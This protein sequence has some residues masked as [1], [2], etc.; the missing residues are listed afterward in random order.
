MKC[1]RSLLFLFFH[2]EILS[3]A[4]NESTILIRCI[5]IFLYNFFFYFNSNWECEKK[6]S[7]NTEWKQMKYTQMKFMQPHNKCLECA[8]G[9]R[10]ASIVLLLFQFD[11]KTERS[12]FFLLFRLRL[13]A[14]KMFEHIVCMRKTVRRNIPFD[15]GA[16][17]IQFH[18]F[19]FRYWC[20]PREPP[21]SFGLRLE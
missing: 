7:E 21:L 11:I 9:K 15:R 13:V 3:T 8:R 20:V 16:D 4:C 18:H 6:M 17:F 2:Y 1:I 14:H 12:F 5:C 19:F 10:D